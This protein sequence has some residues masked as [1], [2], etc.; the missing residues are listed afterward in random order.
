MTMGLVISLCVECACSLHSSR[1][2]SL[3]SGFLPQ[4]KAMLYRLIGITY[5]CECVRLTPMMV[6]PSLKMDGWKDNIK[7]RHALTVF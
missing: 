5:L 2:S 6:S 3:Y 4:S 1:V 7:E